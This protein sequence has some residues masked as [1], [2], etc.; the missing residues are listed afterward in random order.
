MNLM[1]KIK[2]LKQEKRKENKYKIENELNSILIESTK[3]HSF[4]PY[5]IFEFFGLKIDIKKINLIKNFSL[6]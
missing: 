4:V 3:L 6:N 2:I 1:L 5:K